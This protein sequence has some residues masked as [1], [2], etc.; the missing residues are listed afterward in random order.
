MITIM[1]NQEQRKLQGRKWRQVEQSG[2]GEGVAET[3]GSEVFFPL[4]WQRG[5]PAPAAE[6]SSGPTAPNPRLAP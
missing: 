4:P 1:H 3:V 2:G 5:W 6:C